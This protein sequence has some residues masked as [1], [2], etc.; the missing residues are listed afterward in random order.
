MDLQLNGKR[1]FVTGSTA[2]IGFAIAGA[3]AKEGVSVIL[4]GRTQPRVDQAIAN[5]TSSSTGL[6]VQ[7]I[8]ADLGSPEGAQKAIERFPDVDIL[9]NNLSIFE[10]KPFEKITDADWYHVFEV[11]LLSGVRLS[12][13]Y[14]PGMK[15]R[16]WVGSFLFRASRLC[17]SRPK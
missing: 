8:A 14:L 17:K 15:Q 6:A 16:N 10:P 1:A 3:L 9:V 12:R 5:L 4:N 7:G 2:G 11:N 13:H